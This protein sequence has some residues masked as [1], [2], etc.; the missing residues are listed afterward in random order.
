MYSI[1][2]QILCENKNRG[3]T[4]VESLIGDKV[5]IIEQKLNKEGFQT[6]GLSVKQIATLFFALVDILF[7]VKGDSFY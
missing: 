4:P 2:N 3:V 1:Y 6:K 7:I 5:H